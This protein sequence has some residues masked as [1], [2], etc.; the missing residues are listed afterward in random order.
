MKFGKIIEGFCIL[1]SIAIN[2]M[3][4]CGERHYSLQFAWLWWYIQFGADTQQEIVN[5]YINRI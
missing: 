2:W 5:K 1:T 3:V 4:F